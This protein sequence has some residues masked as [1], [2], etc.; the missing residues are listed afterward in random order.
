MLKFIQIVVVMQRDAQHT[1]L[2]GIHLYAAL[3]LLLM[4]GVVSLIRLT[5]YSS[6]VCLVELGVRQLISASIKPNMMP[7]GAPSPSSLAGFWCS[8]CGDMIARML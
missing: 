7:R 1:P 6:V 8:H 3:G 2:F 5:F 4:E